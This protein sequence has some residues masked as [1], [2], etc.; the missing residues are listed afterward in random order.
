MNN[1]KKVFVNM[2]RKLIKKGGRKAAKISQDD[3]LS[4]IRVAMAK[5]DPY[6][7]EDL[8]DDFREDNNLDDNDSIDN[9]LLNKYMLKNYINIYALRE[10]CSKLDSD[11]NKVVFDME[12]YE[13]NN[14]SGNE[15]DGNLM[16]LHTLE[17]GLTLMG[18]YAGG[19]WEFPLFFI[20]Y[21]DCKSLRGYIPSYGNTYN[22]D[23]KTAFGSEEECDKYDEVLSKHYKDA[24]DND[25]LEYYIERQGDDSTAELDFNW[26]AIRED[27]ENRIVVN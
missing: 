23:F 11:L 25:L 12:N 16:G 17:N 10:G 18:F 27:I 15:P 14:N 20:V 1:S 7:V 9:L 4:H 2:D 22:I 13:S 5:G 19:D 3:F 26:E 24:D 8:L 21:W 6:I